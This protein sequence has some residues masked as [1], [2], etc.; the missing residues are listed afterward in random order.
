MLHSN[1][2]TPY[3]ANTVLVCN[4]FKDIVN[5]TD[6]V[7]EEQHFTIQPIFED[8]LIYQLQ[9]NYAKRAHLSSYFSYE[10]VT[11]CTD[12]TTSVRNPLCVKMSFICSDEIDSFTKITLR[13]VLNFMMVAS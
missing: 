3:I 13:L 8:R 7:L 10:S 4:P 2:L 6:V 12:P 11:N 9:R 5:G 1:V